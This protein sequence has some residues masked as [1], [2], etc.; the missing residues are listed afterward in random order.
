MNHNTFWIVNGTELITTNA[1]PEITT[2]DRDMDKDGNRVN[3]LNIV[4][5]LIFNG[6]TIQCG[7][8]NSNPLEVTRNVTLLL[9]GIF[10]PLNNMLYT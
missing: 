4:G 2:D 5:K 3:T 8:S 6:T 7:A 9:Q 1:P 10:R